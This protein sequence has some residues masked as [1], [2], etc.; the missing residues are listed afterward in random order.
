[1]TS[2]LYLLGHFRWEP[3]EGEPSPQ[4]RQ[5]TM[6]ILAMLALSPSGVLRRQ[7]LADVL[8]ETGKD[9]K[10][11]LRQAVKEIRE[12]EQNLGSS[13]FTA[14]K[15]YLKLDLNTLWVD[16]RLASYCAKQFDPS[17]AD[18]LLQCDF[19]ELLMDCAVEGDAFEEWLLIERS[20]TERDL[21]RSLELYLDYTRD[22]TASSH[23]SRHIASAL[24]RINP[25]D[26]QA[27][28]A[29]IQSYLSDNN[30]SAAVQQFERYKNDLMTN[31]GEEPS[32]EICALLDKVDIGQKL[33]VASTEVLRSENTGPE[34]NL[35]RPVI[36][37]CPFQTNSIETDVEYFSQVFRADLC[38]QISCNRRYSIRDGAFLTDGFS[39]GISHKSEQPPV[40]YIVRATVVTDAQNIS[41][42]VQLLEGSSADILWMKRVVCK[43]WEAL[44]QLQGEAIQAAIELIRFV[45]LQEL[46]RA[47]H[48]EEVRLTARQCVSRARLTMFK[49][50][51]DAVQTAEKYLLRALLIEP[52]Y[53]EAMAWLAFLR[54]IEIGQGYRSDSFSVDE[55]IRALMQRA[56]ELSPNDD[57]VLSIFGHLEAFVHHDFK[58]A[59]EY[60]DRAMKSNPNCAY[61][62]GFKAITLC[63]L[64]QSDDALAKLERC[65]QV[66]PFDPHPYYFDTARC[67]ASMLSGHFEE[68]VRLGKQVLRNSP[69]FHANYRPLISSLGHLN[70][71][72]EAEQLIRK[73]KEYQPDFSVGWHLKN[74]PPLTEDKN[75]LY[76]TGLRKAGVRE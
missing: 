53:A 15:H 29:L 20:R 16:A 40:S 43:K 33:T 21:F 37:I 32:A 11:S 5:K 42:L 55:E 3:V 8:W 58:G 74:Y 64:G 22:H 67:I 59:I 61:A 30:R 63:Y 23:K 12:I 28:H 60:F 24:L 27:H 51:P 50:T 2:R 57:N 54:S 73:F 75:D 9:P 46:E 38:Q 70:R 69:N 36:E 6:A 13:I 1:M 44:Q 52:K 56:N 66:M 17:L 31:F 49:F 4:L 34:S 68:A 18:Q 76:I 47:N 19:G 45:E 72:E 10:A 14:D 41:I 62:W 71:H 48:T 7:K 26:E 25:S 65:R 39:S 35:L